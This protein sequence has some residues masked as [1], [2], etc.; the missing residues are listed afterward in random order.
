MFGTMIGKGYSVKTAILDMDMVAEGYFAA[1]SIYEINKNYKVNM[2]ISEAVYRI[3]Y[4]RV[5]P[6]KMIMEL[7]NKLS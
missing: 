6:K 5:P 1:R 7:T 4:E 3:L 2:P